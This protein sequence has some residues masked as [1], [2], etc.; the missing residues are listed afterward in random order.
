MFQM[1]K[2]TELCIREKSEPSNKEDCWSGGYGKKHI[3]ISSIVEVLSG[4]QKRNT[5]GKGE[6]LSYR[7][8]ILLLFH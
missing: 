4:N 7:V 2:T 1:T 5:E 6:D 3:L 8:V